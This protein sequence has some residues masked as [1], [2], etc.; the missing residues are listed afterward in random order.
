MGDVLG[1][2]ASKGPGDE[3]VGRVVAA[4]WRLERRLG[5]G[6]F[7]A[8]YEA[9]DLTTHGRVA[10]KLVR[11]GAGAGAT[12]RLR[13]EGIHAAA[14][15]HP[16]VVRIFRVGEEPDGTVFAAMELVDGVSLGRLIGEQAPVSARRLDRVVSQ[17][18]KGLGAI[19]GAGVL[20][21]D[22]KPDN[23]MVSAPFGEDDHV[24]ILDFGIA[25]DQ[26]GWMT[27]ITAGMNVVGTVEYMAPER[28]LGQV[29]DVR[30]D[31]YAVGLIA[32]ELATGLYP[33]ALS[34]V[35][36][37]RQVQAIL[38]HQS[39]VPVPAAAVIPEVSQPI[40]AWIARMLEKDPAARYGSASLALGAWRAACDE[41][42]DRAPAPTA[43]RAPLAI[44]RAELGPPPVDLAPPIA[45]RHHRAWLRGGLAA[46]VL[47]GA[48]FAAWPERT[49]IVEIPDHRND[50]AL[51]APPVAAAVGP[52]AA[53]AEMRRPRADTSTAS[54]G[55]KPVLAAVPLGAAIASEG[56]PSHEAI[57][58]APETA[59]QAAHVGPAH[60]SR[61][62]G[63]TAKPAAPPERAKAPVTP[64]E[65]PAELFGGAGQ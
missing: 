32:Y 23:V 50:S 34:G 4:I 21:R 39:Q 31:L 25:I 22:L 38:A 62:S 1:R 40:S 53:E 24:T 60:R 63:A 52:V 30:S 35:G 3:H 12:E 5:T 9:I 10:V 58:R 7:G 61:P 29:D 59:P 47:G 57:D 64:R 8:V 49:L 16:N 55:G 37:E 54:P 48:A 41:V 56:Q 17:L 27:R 44:P 2:P 13:H 28:A 46:V 18:L 14:V 51:E 36:Q 42:A 33:F 19:H 45:E 26:T 15:H 11:P 20:H 65:P 43:L 6:A